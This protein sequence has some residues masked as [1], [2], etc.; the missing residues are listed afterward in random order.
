MVATLLL[1]LLCGGGVGACTCCCCCCCAALGFDELGQQQSPLRQGVE[2]SEG[3]PAQ[4]AIRTGC[5]QVGRVVRTRELQ[6]ISEHRE[7]M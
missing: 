7:S 3:L 5:L 1:L 2:C 6:S 4:A